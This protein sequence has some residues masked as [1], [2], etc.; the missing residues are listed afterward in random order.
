MA[1]QPDGFRPLVITSLLLVLRLTL[2][3]ADCCSARSS[4]EVKGPFRIALSC[5]IDEDAI[6]SRRSNDFMVLSLHS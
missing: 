1:R 6:V 2:E 3:E 4:R 5:S